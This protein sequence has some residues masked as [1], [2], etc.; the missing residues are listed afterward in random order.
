MRL[1]RI[2]LNLF[3][4]LDSVYAE[5]NL[6]RAAEVL[7]LTQPAI[8]NAL[9]RLR[10]ALDDPLFVRTP[11]G[12]LPTPMVESIM[13]AVHEALQL[14]GKSVGEL[15]RFDPARAQRTYRF[16]M[17]DLGEAL[18]LPP[19]LAV[20][21]REAPQCSVS[22][23]YV[24]R[25]EAAAD[26][27]SGQLDLVI[28]APLIRSTQLCHQPLASQPYVCVMR[29]DHPLARG[30][31]TLKRFLEATHIHVSSRRRGRGQVDLA[32]DRLGHQRRIVLRVRHYLI[33][34]RIVEQSDHLWTVPLALARQ[35]PLA[36]SRLPFRV[37]DLEWHLYWHKSADGDPANRWLRQK[38][39]DVCGSQLAPLRR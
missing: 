6:T 28:D 20:M 29:R 36:V 25:D 12:M 10:T 11:A 3:R 33:A 2:D 9:A 26:L 38:C 37:D 31:L 30:R 17:N 7:H 15:R 13:P 21:E 5:R 27:A 19:L 18:L 22:S 23:F 35:L 34:A 4:V 1:D 24:A 39:V 14:L 8:S 32:L 16:S